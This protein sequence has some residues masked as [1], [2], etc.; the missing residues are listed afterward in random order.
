[1]YTVCMYIHVLTYI[2]LSNGVNNEKC[3]KIKIKIQVDN[4]MYTTV[5]ISNVYP[6]PTSRLG[7]AGVSAPPSGRC[8]AKH[9]RQFG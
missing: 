5:Y 8:G 9:K 2:Y 3:N 7:V 4:C 6:S 1:M